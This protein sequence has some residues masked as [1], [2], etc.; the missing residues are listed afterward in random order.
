[1]IAESGATVI[2][3]RDAL[4]RAP[5]DTTQIGVDEPRLAEGELPDNVIVLARFARRARRA[6]HR[7]WLGDPPEGEA[8]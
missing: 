8:A 5:K 2:P 1:M 6:H 3:F 4:L 7:F